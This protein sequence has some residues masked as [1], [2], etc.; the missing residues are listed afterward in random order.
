MN[1]GEM[2]YK[3]TSNRME[4][5]ASESRRQ[6]I[7]YLRSVSASAVSLNELV[8]HLESKSDIFRDPGKGSPTHTRIQLVHID[9]PK[10][11]A[12]GVIEWNQRQN[13]ICYNSDEHLE[14]ILDNAEGY[15]LSPIQ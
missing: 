4:L 9:L 10:L 8:H 3:S 6:I 13:I 7:D 12:Y 14:R 11:A 5:L 15:D 1:V 2:P